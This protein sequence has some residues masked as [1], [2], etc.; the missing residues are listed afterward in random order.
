MVQ[1][2]RAVAGG[3]VTASRL[4]QLAR[5]V[6]V[7]GAPGIVAFN[8]DGRLRGVTGFTVRDGKIVEINVLA[9]PERLRGIEVP[10]G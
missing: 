7:N 3:A 2:A 5:V 6:L 10:P 9:D 1:G 4:A 8:P